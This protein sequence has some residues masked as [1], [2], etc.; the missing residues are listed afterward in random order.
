MRRAILAGAVLSAAAVAALAVTLGAG[1]PAAAP[2]PSAA[3]S[4]AEVTRGDLADSETV[5]GMLAYADERVLRAGP[6]G[7][8]TAIKAKG[9]SVKRGQT[10]YTVDRRPVTLFYGKIPIYRELSVGVNGADVAQLERNLK[11]LGYGTGMTVDDQ[12]TTA[13]A[14]AV[15]GW[16]ADRNLPVT[17]A[18]DAAQAAVLPGQ[19]W[20]KQTKAQVG[21]PVSAGTELLV[22]RSTRRVVAIDLDIADQ[23]LARKGAEVEMELPGGARL[24]G[25]ISKVGVV[26]EVS[27]DSVTVDV[28]VAPR[29][30]TGALREVPV[31]VDLRSDTRED[32]L[33]VPVEALLALREGGYGV[34]TQQGVVITVTPGLFAGGRV[35]VTG[36]G[37][38]EG[39][40]VEVPAS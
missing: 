12:F 9:T 3:P 26:A 40:K 5:E 38:S 29:G 33:S 1:E 11:A 34:R 15:A 24:K 8:L 35:E 22:V 21:D 39:M 28:E 13:T 18:V 2:S 7:T 4:Y 23:H 20:V 36:A 6:S 14:A 30:S 27:E 17:G 25:T 10:L 37:L 32:V 19:A 31:T 16:Q